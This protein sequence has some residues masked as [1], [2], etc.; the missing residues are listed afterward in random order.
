[1]PT[2]HKLAAILF[3]DIAGYT[4]MMQDNEKNALAVLNWFEEALE[5]I[6]PK[7]QGRIVKYFG[8]GCLL[9]FDS[10]S[11]SV[12]CAIALQKAFR[13][14]PLV[15]VR[16]GLHLGDV[17]FKNDNVFGD[18]VNIASR[19]ESLGIPGSILLSK[20]IRDQIKNKA[21]F[22]LV[23]LGYFDFKNVSESMEIF[24][25]AN[26]GLVVPVKEKMSGK[27]K[28]THQKSSGVKWIIT[29]GIVVL[30]LVLS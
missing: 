5:D 24:A 27:L 22:V 11:N 7:H 28:E 26:D 21:E 8:D 4:A 19:I 30:L 23:S 25:L 2:D 12:D 17:V 14:P 15:P 13:E 10:T 9:A 20:T 18:G 1:M 3:A 16:I 29:S 6:V